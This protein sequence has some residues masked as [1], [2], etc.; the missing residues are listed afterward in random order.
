M[1]AQEALTES[2]EDGDMEERVGGQLMELNP[3]NEEKTAE[4]FMDRSG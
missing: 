1:D 3:V 2:D 4:E